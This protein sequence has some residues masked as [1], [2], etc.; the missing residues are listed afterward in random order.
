GIPAAIGGN[1]ALEKFL[2]PSFTATEQVRLENGGGV[3]LQA[4]QASAEHDAEPHVSRN[5]E[6]GL[7]GF[8]LLVAICGIALAHKFYV[9]NPEISER[10]AEQWAGAHKVLTNKYYVD[11][12]YDATAISGTFGAGRGLWAV[13]RK[14]VDGAVNGTG[15]ST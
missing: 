11:E 7:M 8:S 12:L 1:N 5:V 4:D 9:N 15:W 3:R 10:L 14:V 13:D 6:I 2:E